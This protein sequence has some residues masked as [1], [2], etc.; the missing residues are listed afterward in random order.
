M[1]V[2]LKYRALF[3]LIIVYFFCSQEQLKQFSHVSQKALDQYLNLT[4]QR[5]Q[6]ERRRAQLDAGDEW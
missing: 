3:G 2:L 4:E 6:L 1:G 5:E